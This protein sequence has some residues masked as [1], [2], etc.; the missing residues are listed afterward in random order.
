MLVEPSTGTPV[1]N[2]LS[3]IG[4]ERG[5][6]GGIKKVISQEC[7]VLCLILELGCSPSKE[8]INKTSEVLL[9]W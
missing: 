8:F 3:V 6:T 4:S 7:T 1:E 5:T 9:A 2:S